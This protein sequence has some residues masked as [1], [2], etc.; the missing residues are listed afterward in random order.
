LLF[1]V[2]EATTLCRQRGLKIVS[3]EGSASLW[4]REFYPPLWRKRRLRGLITWLAK[5][6]PPCLGAILYW[7]ASS[8]KLCRSSLLHR[9]TG[10]GMSLRRDV[11]LSLFWVALATMGRK[12]G[13]VAQV[14]FGAP[15]RIPADFGLVALCLVGHRVFE[16]F[17][18]LGFSSALIFVG[19][20]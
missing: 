16:L 7:W 4:A 13:A 17:K 5:V 18:E 11:G 19:T 9:I 12:A 1:H 14:D 10:D 8:S 15:A 6:G 2:R 3:A 20:M